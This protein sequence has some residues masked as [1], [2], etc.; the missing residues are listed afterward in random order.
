MKCLSSE[1]LLQAAVSETADDTQAAHLAEC[2]TCSAAVAQ[3]R[4]LDARLMAAH[5]DVSDEDAVGWHRLMAA[6]EEIDVAASSAAN[7]RNS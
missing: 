2:A 5:T 4:Q 3:W 6:L 7:R 1:E